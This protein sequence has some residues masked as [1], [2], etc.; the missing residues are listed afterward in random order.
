MPIMSLNFSPPKNSNES[1]C[2]IATKPSAEVEDLCEDQ[3]YEVVEM[4]VTSSAKTRYAPA[5]IPQEGTVTQPVESDVK[6]EGT[7]AQEE[8]QETYMNCD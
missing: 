7:A 6:P 1:P 2:K 8:D 4:Q 5:Q 3:M